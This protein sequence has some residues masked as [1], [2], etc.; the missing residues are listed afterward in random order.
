MKKLTLFILAMIVFFVSCEKEGNIPSQT[1]N[2]PAPEVKM[3]TETVSGG[4]AATKATIDANAQFAWTAGDNVAVHVSRGDSHQYVVTSSGASV[5]AA[6]AKF[7]VEYEEGYSRD[8]FALYPSTIVAADAANYGQSGQ[9]L[10]V[11]L[12]SSYTLDQVSGETSPGPMISSNEA[13]NSSWAFYQLCGLLRLT[14]NSIPPSTKRLEI[15]FDGKNVAGNFALSD[16]KGDGSS[17]IALADASG[18]NASVITITNSG[19]T[20]FDGWA[21]GKVFNLPLPAGAYTNLTVTAYNALT[22]GDV[23]LTETRPFVYTA[24]HLHGT[25]QTASFQVFSINTSKTKRVIFAPGNLQAT[26]TDLG[27]TW[28]WHFAKNQYDYIGT[29]VSNNKVTGDGKVSQNGTVDLF[30]KSTTAYTTYGISNSGDYNNL[31]AGKFKDWGNLDIDGKGENYWRTLTIAG[32][33]DG[34]EWGYL[35]ISRTTG[36]IVNGTGN[37][38][39]TMAQV[40]TDSSKPVNGLIIFPDAFVGGTFAGVTWGTINAASSWST[41]CTT[42]GWASLEAAGCVFLPITGRRSNSTG[43]FFDVDKGYYFGNWDNA[44]VAINFK[45]NGLSA[46]TTI[47]YA[48]V[49]VRLVH[50]IQ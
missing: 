34:S 18:N 6:S 10:D 12:P 8:A 42:D 20:L 25:K 16:P 39:Y 21:D 28:D 37:A 43:T 47:N 44:T 45:T 15:D 30:Q 36:T 9:P 3:I 5:S 49:G 26:T 22:D 24:D 1:G 23:V 38:R 11:T 40:N 17:F 41:H 14:V 29:T 33:N 31:Y 13:G 19:N 27:E 32:Q 50:E 7:S 46:H 48:G 4:R 2:E 35:L